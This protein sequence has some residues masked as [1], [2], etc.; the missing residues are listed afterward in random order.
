[1]SSTRQYEKNIKEIS[2]IFL[3][4][5]IIYAFILRIYN[6]GGL[7]GGDESAYGA[8][9][10]YSIQ[11][12]FNIFS[13]FYVL[14]PNE[15]VSY[16]GWLFAR[17]FAIL[18]IIPFLMTLGYTE[19]S[20]RLPSVLFSVFSIPLLY[21][22]LRK[23]DFDVRIIL[24][25][26]FLFAIIPLNVDFSRIGR[27]ES[28]ITFYCLLIAYLVIKGIKD[29]NNK[30]FYFA[31]IIV[32]MNLLT[33]NV[34]G[35]FPLIALVPYLYFERVS[36]EQLKHIAASISFIIGLLLIYILIPFLFGKNFDFWL[37]SDYYIA[38]TS[39]FQQSS[40]EMITVLTI[41]I[42]YLLFTPFLALIAIPTLM[43]IFYS[44][45]RITTSSYSLWFFWFLSS[46][47]ML[48]IGGADP[49]RFML[50]TPAY[51]V[52]ASIGIV[53]SYSAFIQ[54]KK[55]GFMFPLLIAS[56]SIYIL[57]IIYLFPHLFQLE[58]RNM[59]PV[60]TTYHVLFVF[61]FITKY[62]IMLVL[63][64][65]LIS[66]IFCV[67]HYKKEL[68]T[69]KISIKRISIAIIVAYLLINM[70]LINILVTTGVGEFHRPEEVRVVADY[71][72]SNLNSEKYGC[73][74]CLHSNSFTFYTQKI[75]PY[76]RCAE[77]DWVEEKVKNGDLKYFI[78]NLYHTGIVGE[79]GGKFYLT[80]G[81]GRFNLKT[82][83]PEKYEWLTQNCMD[84]TYKTGLSPDNKYFRVYEYVN[85]TSN[86]SMINM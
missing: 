82:A 13:T 80:R 9:A 5:L 2:Y 81:G 77:I 23:L 71:L 85:S 21:L 47:L 31:G 16:S 11:P 46:F 79:E 55:N 72:K 44:L 19:L 54:K 65:S 8:F 12:H 59:V 28:A 84:V 49:H 69:P 68:N 40:Y 62:F 67:F 57:S 4:A 51:V 7:T 73:V 14:V 34:R 33:T 1:M 64:F 3:I 86:L 70:L 78:Y 22:I 63:A 61:S 25:S 32:V 76:W 39:R 53:Y 83:Y 20:I 15:P 10:F 36:K 37:N 6:V 38:A 29:E 26:C 18:P 48:S 56:T 24:M 43:G 60:L 66:F 58:W 30:L 50:F 75:C 41:Y 52:L 17:P 42:K 74:A 45:K 35:I 27:I